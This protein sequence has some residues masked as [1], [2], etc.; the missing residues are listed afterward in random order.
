MSISA[1]E[2]VIILTS[3]SRLARWLLYQHKEQQKKAGSKCW[4]TP[5]VLYLMNWLETLWKKS[6]PG[7]HILTNLQSIK[8][9]EKIIRGDPST[10]RLNL[11]HLKG[12]AVRAD[13]AYR[14]I[15]Q[16][17]LTVKPHEFQWTYESDAFYRWMKKYEFQYLS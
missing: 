1:S 4:H 2:G 3:S 12:T 15:H 5:T 7:Q 6:W 13:Q 16:Y 17:H 9:W 8:L 11:L 14:L 10:P